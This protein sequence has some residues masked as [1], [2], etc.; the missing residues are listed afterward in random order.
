MLRDIVSQKKRRVCVR[1]IIYRHGELLCQVLKNSKGTAEDFWCTPG[2]GLEVGESLTDGLRREMIEETGIEPQIGNLLFV[3]QFAD[4]WGDEVNEGLEFFFH[5]KNHED[6][7]TINLGATSHGTI[8]VSRVAFVAPAT[9]HVLPAFLSNVSIDDYISGAL[10]PLIV[11][12]F[13][14]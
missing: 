3:Q 14:E 4:K 6:Y 1:G 10:P 7:E 2:G 8:E 11:D 5:I 9:H 13:N 12:N